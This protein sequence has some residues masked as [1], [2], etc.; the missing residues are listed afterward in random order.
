MQKAAAPVRVFISYAHESERHKED[1]LDLWVFLRTYGIDAQLDREAAARRRNWPIW[2]EQ[3]IRRSD[4]VLVVLSGTYRQRAEDAEAPGAGRGV[5]YE[6]HV[7]SSLLYQDLPTWLP[8]IL[9]VVLPGGSADDI[10]NYLLV[11]G[12]CYRITS[13]TVDGAEELLRVLTDQPATVEPALGKVPVLP[14]TNHHV[15]VRVVSEGD[16]LVSTT[17]LAGEVLGRQSAPAAGDLRDGRR[18]AKVLFTDGTAGRLR[19]L[20]DESPPGS[21]VEIVV[22]AAEAVRDLPFESAELPDGRRLGSLD[23]VR[24]RTVGGLVTGAML[25]AV[26]AETPLVQRSLHGFADYLDGVLDPE[27]DQDDDARGDGRATG[28]QAEPDT[29]HQAAGPHGTAQHGA[30]DSQGQRP[31]QHPALSQLADDPGGAQKA[32]TVSGGFD[33]VRSGGDDGADRYDDDDPYDEDDRYDDDDDLGGAMD[34]G[35]DDSDY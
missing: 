15:V 27:A 9:P 18:L 5:K 25:A 24:L 28:D 1:V 31:E 11:A 21:T 4:F 12:T 32:A 6:T 16:R 23:R 34:G 14:P 17:T 35:T 30:Q 19:R 2:I 10:P 8:K 26:L 20:V 33:G 7:L 13:F 22:E 3:E 29:A